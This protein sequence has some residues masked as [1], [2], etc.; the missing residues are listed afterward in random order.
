MNQDFTYTT[1]QNNT[2]S[3]TVYGI[4]KWGQQPCVLYI[5][6]FKGF[7]DWGFVPYIGNRF[8]ENG[9]CFVSF[10]F[11]HNGI[12]ED[13]EVFSEMDKFAQNTL[14]LELNEAKEIIRLCTSHKLFGDFHDMP[15]GVLAHSRGG[16]LGIIASSENPEVSALVTWASVCTY[17]RY[18]KNMKAEWRAKGYMEVENARTKQVFQMNVSFL[19]DLEKNAKTHLNVLM[20]VKNLGKPLLIVHG[21]RDT[22]VPFFEAEQLNV[23]AYPNTTQYHLVANADHTFGATHPFVGT[24]P[25]LEEV[26]ERTIAFFQKNL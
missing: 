24:T 7:K 19:E 22:S 8:A 6:G 5:H 10:N 17:E 18:E 16:G 9:F 23:Y 3:I 13:K 4:E 26:L 25:H 20:H 2:L 12:G 1:R 21:D 14:S 11:S 15:I